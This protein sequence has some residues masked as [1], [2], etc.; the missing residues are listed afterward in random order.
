MKR[1]I[2]MA[3]AV[4]LILSMAGCGIRPQSDEAAREESS[5]EITTEVIRIEEA[6]KAQSQSSPQEEKQTQ[7]E[8]KET[9]S[10]K[11]EEREKTETTNGTAHESKATT[12]TAAS[13]TVPKTESA[14]A[15][16]VE[17]VTPKTE[18]TA[19]T[20]TTGNAD[21]SWA[22]IQQEI[23]AEIDR[24]I[25]ETMAMIEAEKGIHYD[26]CYRQCELINQIRREN[27]L[28][29]LTYDYS[30]QY[31]ADQVV[32]DFWN[33]KDNLP[34]AGVAYMNS[35]WIDADDCINH[36][37]GTNLK[38]YYLD[39]FYTSMVA[40]HYADDNG[41]YWVQ[42]FFADNSLQQSPLEIIAELVGPEEFEKLFPQ[43]Q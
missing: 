26:Y 32:T 23:N 6:E 24:G 20:E 38:G 4:M 17:S 40:G 37:A 30:K 18:T 34:V 19:P 11:V 2:C 16:S 25:A 35:I 3:L 8:I 33:Q 27:G 43:Q 36:L 42:L 41:S 31:M 12:E 15:A 39:S 7:L 1:I 13:V 10:E 5:T 29:E 14:P 9:A 21:K 28:D 22:E